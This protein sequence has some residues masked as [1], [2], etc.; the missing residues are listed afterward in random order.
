MS[1]KR[2]AVPLPGSKPK[3]KS[4]VAP[5]KSALSQELIGSDDDSSAES[6]PRA[7][8]AEKPKATIGVH[9]PNGAAKPSAKEKSTTKAVPKSKPAP[10]TPA[11]KRI[12]QEQVEE[13]SSSEVSDDSD[14]PAR[15]IQT[16]LPGEVEMKDASSGSDS[17][18]DSDSSSEDETAKPAQKPA[19][20]APSKPL[21]VELRA[22]KP[23]TPPKGYN[24][25]SDK[26]RT[27]S[28]AAK[29][30][31]NV[32][33][34]Q[35][36]HITAPADVSL[37]ELETIAMD[38]AMKGDSIL[39]HKGT[40]YGFSTTE[41]SEDGPREILVPQKNGYSAIPAKISQT[42]HL[43]Q[44]V[45]LPKL[46]SKQADPN[47]GSEAAAS[48][49]RSTIR[50][51][52]PQVKGLKMRYVPLG[53]VGGDS[54]G[55]LGDTD[56]ED[57]DV[58]QERAGLAAPNGLNLPTKAPKRKHTEANGEEAPSKKVKKH[59]TPEEMKKKEEKKAK[60][61]KKSKA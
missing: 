44:V 15:D 55:V 9:R 49:T 39:N 22:A 13:L 17:D 50:A 28:K 52:R 45:R 32:Q 2:T 34:K 51:P 60:K 56:S 42:L 29:I 35:I 57:D 23:Y 4:K 61:E 48:I 33:G 8:K 43:Q 31:D 25:V 21:E 47:T 1:A 18:S 36:W 16:K 5:P 24:L 11:P 54:G 19:Q 26:D 53:F 27:S 41:K 7:K 38:K 37:K 14:A 58:P 6:A 12:T 46:S 10:K 30:F 59:K 20:P 3:S 40:D